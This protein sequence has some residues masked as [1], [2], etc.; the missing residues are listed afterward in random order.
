MR[1][2]VIALVVGSLVSVVGLAGAQGLA[3]V[4]TLELSEGSVAAGI[5]FSWGSGH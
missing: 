5:G 1:R 4:S 2:L 3:P